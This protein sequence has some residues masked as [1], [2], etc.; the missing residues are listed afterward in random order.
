MEKNQ[1]NG[2][3]FE[4]GFPTK[5][6]FG[7]GRLD[8]CG[9]IVSEFNPKKILLVTSNG[10][11]KRLGYVDRLVE[12][13]SRSTKAGIAVFDGISGE[14]SLETCDAVAAFAGKEKAEIVMGLGGGSVLDTAKAAAML[15]AN[16]GNAADYAEKKGFAKKGVPFIAIPGT[17]GSGSEVTRA[18]VFK[19]STRHEKIV[20][21]SDNS[22]PAAAIV[23][24]LITLSCPPKVT[25]ESGMDVLTHAVEAFVSSAASPVTDAF[26]FKAA[27]LV[28]S[29]LETAFADGKNVRA[30]HDMSLASLLS[31]MAISNA[32]TGACHAFAHSIGGK[33]GVSHGRINAVML[34]HVMKLNLS[35]RREKFGILAKA[36]GKNSAEE[37]IQR[38]K[39]LAQGVG[40]TETLR[41][42][43]I[44]NADFS[45]IA[46]GCFRGT[47]KRN[48]K[49]VSKPDL[50]GVLE[51]AL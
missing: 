25:A 28:N 2:V 46:D 1:L 50:L 29:S 3:K 32:G 6:F 14:P 23:D 45:S 7:G 43:G 11:M 21:R 10:S 12:S 42:F 17:S 4:F 31:G 22:F 20:I 30:R 16:R 44:T 24:P 51:K 13:V 48:P 19:D 38:V 8:D 49:E 18:S 41:D 34:P 47:I 36:F 26:A 33:F 5:I 27:M 9:K 15:A 39:A 37:A 40:I 35:A